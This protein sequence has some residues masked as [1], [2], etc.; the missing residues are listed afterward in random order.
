MTGACSKP[1]LSTNPL[2]TAR[3]GQYTSQEVSQDKHFPSGA[4]FHTIPTLGHPFMGFPY[5]G[6]PHSH[7]V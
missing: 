7:G 1:V 5:Y 2:I 3:W 6:N 4:L